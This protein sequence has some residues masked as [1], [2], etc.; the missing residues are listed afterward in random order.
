MFDR[1][2]NPEND[3]KTLTSP[4]IQ[5]AGMVDL[6][7]ALNT[8]VYLEGLDLQGNP[9]N[10]SKIALR[11]NPDIAKGDIKLSFLAHN[12][13]QEDLSYDVKLTVMR[14]ALAH[15]NDIVTKDYNF[16]GEID[17]VESLS[18]MSYYDTDV[19]EMAIATGLGSRDRDS[20]FLSARQS[21]TT[22][23]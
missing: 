7:G 18:G 22:F 17:S 1:E 14:P 3:V 16:K 6:D 21:H 20:L 8:M 12:E 4:R 10:K 23:T 13:S 2:N 11:N 5:G 15:P 19:K 9:I